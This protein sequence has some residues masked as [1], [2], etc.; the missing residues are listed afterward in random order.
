MTCPYLMEYRNTCSHQEGVDNCL[1]AGFCSIADDC[2]KDEYTH[3]THYVQDAK[4]G[5]TVCGRDFEKVNTTSDIR[6]ATCETCL[7]II[8]KEL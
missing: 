6:L 7:K 5:R 3:K 4:T 8:E 2:P 1:T